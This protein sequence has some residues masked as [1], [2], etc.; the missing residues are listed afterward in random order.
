MN[1]VAID[2]ETAA[3]ERSSACAVG[4][5]VVEAGRVVESSSW[6]IRPPGNRYNHHNVRIHGITPEMTENAGS[7]ADLWPTLS[8]YVEGRTLVAHNAAFDKGVLVASLGHHGIEEPRA[9]FLCTLGLARK[10]YPEMSSHTLPLVAARCGVRLGN[11]HDAAADAEAAAGIALTMVRHA[12]V[13]CLVSLAERL[14]V[15]C[16]RIGHD[17]AGRVAS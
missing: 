11:H 9:S 10:L 15:R 14:G 17:D 16:S 13:P 5:T 7:M 4:V 2:F 12:G 8:A 3:S 1:W 6:L